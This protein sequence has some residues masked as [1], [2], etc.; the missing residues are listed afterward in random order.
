MLVQGK[1]AVVTGGA[2]GIG[3]GIAGQLAAHGATVVIADL[4]RA[5]A[6]LAATELAGGAVAIQTDVTL[7]ASVA[8]LVEDAVDVYA[9]AIEEKGLDLV[10]RIEPVGTL[11]GNQHLMFQALTNLLDN[12]MKY[13]P[14]GGTISVAT[15]RDG[16]KVQIAVADN[17]PGIPAQMR[18]RVLQR[19]VR[20]D[21]SRTTPGSGLGLS[22]VAA[23]ARMHE[24][25]LRFDDANP[26]LRTTLTFD[27]RFGRR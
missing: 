21:H 2:S 19:F 22:L 9:P 14:E 3:R 4:D 24:A 25:D 13:T 6:E 1:V 8:A 23:V 27:V 12:A 18:E 16:D 11:I 26:G 5:A 10:R 7:E 15:R 17:G 20:L